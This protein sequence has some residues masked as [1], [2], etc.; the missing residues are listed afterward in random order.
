[1]LGVRLRNSQLSL[2]TCAARIRIAFGLGQSVN[3]EWIRGAISSANSGLGEFAC[4]VTMDNFAH[5]LLV[6]I[7]TAPPDTKPPCHN[8]VAA[9]LPS[10]V[11][12]MYRTLG[13]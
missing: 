7:S 12:N 4:G 9:I 6:K 2:S 3:P 1:M 8:L 13:V 5:K 11:G 10:E